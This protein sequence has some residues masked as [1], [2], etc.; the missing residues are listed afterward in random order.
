MHAAQIDLLMIEIDEDGPW[1]CSSTACAGPCAVAGLVN[2]T[3]SWLSDSSARSWSAC[4]TGPC[5]F[6][7]PSTAASKVLRVPVDMMVL[8]NGCTLEYLI[9]EMQPAV[10]RIAG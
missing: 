9:F 8:M 7:Y 6:T 3:D 1:F 5:T 10:Y 2:E 4:I